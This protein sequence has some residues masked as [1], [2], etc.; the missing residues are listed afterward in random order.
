MDAVAMNENSKDVEVK[1]R[2]FVN[3][4]TILPEP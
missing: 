1:T 2:G 4:L 3:L